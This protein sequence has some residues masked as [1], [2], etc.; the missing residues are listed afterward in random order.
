MRSP[1]RGASGGEQIAEQQKS[2]NHEEREEHEGKDENE[3]TADSLYA[4]T[5]VQAD[6]FFFV[7]FV[8]FVV[9]ALHLLLTMPPVKRRAARTRIPE[10]FPA[11]STR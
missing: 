9:I 11:T 5:D 1:E 8:P 4:V 2:I 3:L 6:L 7:V 10:T